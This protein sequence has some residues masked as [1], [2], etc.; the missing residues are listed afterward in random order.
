LKKQDKYKDAEPSAID[1]FKEMH[2]SKKKGFS[3]NVQKA[4][5]D[6]EEMVVT[7]VQDGQQPKYPTEVVYS[8]QLGS[9]VFLCNLGL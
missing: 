5:V 6:M 1:L 7:S 4:I 3:K 8:V 2:C 9:S